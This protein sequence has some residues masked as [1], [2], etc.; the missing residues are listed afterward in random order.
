VDAT[1]SSYTSVPDLAREIDLPFFL[2]TS[3]CEVDEQERSPS[4]VRIRLDALV[5]QA[6]RKGYGVGIIHARAATLRVLEERL[7]ELAGEGIVVMALSD[8]LE[9]HALQ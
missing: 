2:A 7:P 8:V 4:G 3:M 9:L 1:Q 5:D 6:R